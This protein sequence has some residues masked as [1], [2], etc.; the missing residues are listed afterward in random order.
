MAGCMLRYMGG[1]I[2]RKCKLGESDLRKPVC[3]NAPWYYVRIERGV[4]RNGLGDVSKKVW[5]ESK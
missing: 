5:A 1:S 4:R 3:L 2:L